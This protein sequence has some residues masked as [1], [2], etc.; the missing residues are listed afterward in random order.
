MTIRADAVSRSGYRLPTEAEWEYACR[1]GAE[2][3]RYYGV[4]V[5]LLRHYAW[6]SATS[7]DRAQPCGSLLP[8]DLG[9]FDMLGNVYE[10]CQEQYRDDKPD[11]DVL[12]DE[13]D[14]GLSIIDKEPR[15]LRR[16]AFNLPPAFARSAN[17][18]WYMPSY[19]YLYYG[20]RLAR[21]YP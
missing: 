21:T 18:N 15:H 7:P 2:T 1:A 4:S 12:I 11:K 16:G 14:I 5:N 6:F 20:F 3:S 8:N 9:L 10:W 17:R 13:I 19:R